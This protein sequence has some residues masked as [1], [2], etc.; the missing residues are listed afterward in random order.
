MVVNIDHLND[1]L[2]NLWN[3]TIY[4]IPGAGHLVNIDAPKAFNE[5]LAAFAKDLF[6]TGAA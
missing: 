5:L 3:K 4:K 1:A 2:I 6:I